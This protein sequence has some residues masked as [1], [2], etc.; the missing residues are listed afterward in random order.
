MSAFYY[1]YDDLQLTTLLQV[2]QVL[3]F[4]GLGDVE[5]PDGAGTGVFGFTFNASDAEIYGAQFEGGLDLPNNVSLDATLLW[6]A[7]A[8]VVNSQDIQDSRFQAD[9]DAANAINRSIEGNRLIRTPEFQFNGSLSKV[10]DVESGNIDGIVSLGYRSSQHMTIFNG[11]DF[12][13]PDNPE[14]RLDDTV[15][16]Y[17][18]IDAGAGYSHGDDGKWRI[19]AYVNNLTGIEREQA[20][21]ITQFDNTRFFSPPR[22]YGLRVR[23]KFQ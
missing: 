23:A 15:D 18:T 19:E 6:L 12:N 16:G 21:I 5:L 22:T 2:Q 9:I 8:Q 1:D 4:E 3:D 13:N 7:E 11:I 10:W 17:F 14:G 20:I